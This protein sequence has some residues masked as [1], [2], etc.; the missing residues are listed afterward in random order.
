MKYVKDEKALRSEE[1]K[2]LYSEL[3]NR[4]GHGPEKIAVVQRTN[5]GE[6]YDGDATVYRSKR[7]AEELKGMFQAALSKIMK[8]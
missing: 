7:N 3:V 2:K 6:P 5:R 8:S 1:L 4:L